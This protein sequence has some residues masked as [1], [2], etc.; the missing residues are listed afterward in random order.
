MI[1]INPLCF[2][3]LAVLFGC[4]QPTNKDNILIDVK[5]AIKNQKALAVSDLVAQVDYVKLET[6]PEVF[7]NWVSNLTI[8]ENFIVL[9]NGFQGYIY[10]FNRKGDFKKKVG[11]IGQGPHEYLGSSSI[12]FT[13]DEE[14]LLVLDQRQ[15]KI[16]KYGITQNTFSY[17]ILK[18][19]A[20]IYNITATEKVIL[21]SVLPNISKPDPHRIIQFDF[22]LNETERFIPFG[23]EM[24]QFKYG[25]GQVEVHKGEIYLAD[26][27]NDAIEVYSESFRLKR[28]IQLTSLDPTEDISGL[29]FWNGE[30]F[31]T[32][33]ATPEMDGKG[34]IIMTHESMKKKIIRIEPDG[35]ASTP[36]D[37]AD[38]TK[39]ITDDLTGL[40]TLNSFGNCT[41]KG[42]FLNHLTVEPMKS[43]MKEEEKSN[44]GQFR[45]YDPMLFGL[46]Q[47]SDEYDN[48][49]IQIYHHK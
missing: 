19:V 1:K 39:G 20:H 5:E 7:I 15:K 4:R 8:S 11:D 32:T 26:P 37:P 43:R 48:P 49:F 41:H 24:E 33:M 40:Y 22:K 9:S 16:L 10:L 17:V 31:L 47:E 42:Y 29:A 38:Q 21:A 46:L 45:K 14:Y 35:H 28:T 23:G 27:V 25:Y 3:L 13:P 36:A 6:I 30:L 12:Q 34:S 18:D 2:L 44:P